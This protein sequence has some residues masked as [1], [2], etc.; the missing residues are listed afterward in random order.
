MLADLEKEEKG[1][2]QR[3]R[4]EKDTLIAPIKETESQLDKLLDMHIQGT[5]TQQEYLS[6]KETL[7]NQKISLGEKW[8]QLK[9][10]GNLW[11]EPCREFLKAAHHA[12]RVAMEKNLAAK[13]DFLKKIGSN[14]CLKSRTLEFSYCIP[15]SLLQNSLKSGPLMNWGG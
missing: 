8:G 7:L 14:F 1:S 4:Q 2:R 6:K 10:G 3:L 12:G 13:R 15:W 5:I 9:E 11:L